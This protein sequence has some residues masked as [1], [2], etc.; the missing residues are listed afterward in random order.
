MRA[1]ER[2][3]GLCFPALE[4]TFDDHHPHHPHGRSYQSPVQRSRKGGGA[5]SVLAATEVSA[6]GSQGGKRF[7]RQEAI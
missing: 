4:G 1:R 6:S 5:L 7:G 2:R 3:A